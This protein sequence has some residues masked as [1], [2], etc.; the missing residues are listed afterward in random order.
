MSGHRGRRQSWKSN[1]GVS[2]S[3]FPAFSSLP[4]ST[5]LLSDTAWERADSDKQWGPGCKPMWPLV[6]MK[7]NSPCHRE[8]RPSPLPHPSIRPHSVSRR[9]EARLAT[10]CNHEKQTK[11]NTPS[12][13]VPK[14]DSLAT[15]THWLA[16]SPP[17]KPDEADFLEPRARGRA[18]KGQ[19][20]L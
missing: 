13:L 17:F 9:G 6:V 4:S 1:T 7:S 16:G 12:Q 2:G 14:I 8:L 20:R 15:Q 11:Q 18:G 5:A 3:K 19:E 10:S